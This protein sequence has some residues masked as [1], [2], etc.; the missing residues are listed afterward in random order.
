VVNFR[1]LIG[2]ISK[3]LIFISVL[4]CPAHGFEQHIS[5]VPPSKWKIRANNDRYLRCENNELKDTPE[6]NNA[7]EFTVESL[8]VPNQVYIKCGNLHL[9]PE[10]SNNNPRVSLTQ[11]ASA[12]SVITLAYQ[13]N[14]QWQLQSVHRDGARH[15]DPM[16]N[17]QATNFRDGKVTLNR[18]TGNWEKF[19]FIRS[20][21]TPNLQIDQ[22]AFYLGSLHRFLA[23]LF[24]PSGIYVRDN[25]DEASILEFTPTEQP[26]KFQ[27]RLNPGGEVLSVRD[28]DTFTIVEVGPNRVQLVTDN[29]Q[30]LSANHNRGIFE[31]SNDRGSW[32]NFALIPAYDL[33]PQM[34]RFKSQP[35]NRNYLSSPYAWGGRFSVPLI[36]PYNSN[37]FLPFVVQIPHRGINLPAEITNDLQQ[38]RISS[39]EIFFAPE[40]ITPDGAN[41]EAL[42]LRPHYW[43]D[44]K[45]PVQFP[46]VNRFKKDVLMGIYGNGEF[47]GSNHLPLNTLASQQ[48]H[49]HD[50]RLSPDNSKIKGVLDTLN[51]DI[52]N[53]WLWTL[54]VNP[55]NFNTIKVAITL[56]WFFRSGHPG[57]QQLQ[58]WLGVHPQFSFQDF[59]DFCQQSDECQPL[60]Q[61]LIARLRA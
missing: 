22:Q 12:N 53:R 33:Q 11:A 47:A 32:Q 29:N 28:R 5:T 44:P 6:E 21:E 10:T 39:Y 35:I 36:H 2:H 23:K 51:L 14:S 18:N 60:L 16:L 4:I 58:Q 43:L 48:V 56:H 7:S 3:L 9:T 8:K 19:V 1:R 50:S 59:L 30:R 26:G 31:L 61:S 42:E 38:F 41:N 45:M 20:A 54:V 37:M 46:R 15:N 25:P 49:I 27:V 13:L 34:Q 24:L 17:V 55:R 40:I 57:D 52:N